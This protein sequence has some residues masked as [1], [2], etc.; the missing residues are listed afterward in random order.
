MTYSE[1]NSGTSGMWCE[2]T[3]SAPPSFTAVLQAQGNMEENED[4]GRTTSKTGPNYQ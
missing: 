1:E 3:I 4:T 2:H